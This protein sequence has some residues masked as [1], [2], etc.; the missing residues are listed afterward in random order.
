MSQKTHWDNLYQSRKAEGLSWFQQQALLS[1][2]LIEKS[3]IALTDAIIDVGGGASTLVDDLV[4]RGYGNLTVLDI[5]QK[6][7]DVV[8]RRLGAKAGRVRWIA[9]DITALRLPLQGYALWHDRATCHFL[10]DAADRQSY[11]QS[12]LRSLRPG[13]HVIIATFAEDGPERCSGRPVR[14]YSAAELRKELGERFVLQHHEKEAHVTPL[15]TL[16]NF[17]YC[18]F[19]LL[20]QGE[21]A[22]DG[23]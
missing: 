18:W 23:A 8:C 4:A 5:S 19:K 16:Q 2:R 7:L 11:V 21:L 6:S 22:A 14:R 20:D 12:L 10:L 3:G 17:N 13:G 1:L 9:G 15:G